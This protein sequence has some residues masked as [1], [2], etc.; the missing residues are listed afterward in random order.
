MGLRNLKKIKHNGKTLEVILKAHEMFW[1][2]KEGG[3]RA[4]LAGADLSG[5][6]LKEM[7][8][9]GAILKLSLIHI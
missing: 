6:D 9:A 7:N 1:A 2:S 5:A 8:L 3:A 4:D